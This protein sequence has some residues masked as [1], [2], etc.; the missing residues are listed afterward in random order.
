MHR[1]SPLLACLLLGAACQPVG[2]ASIRGARFDYNQAIAGSWD[3]QLLLNLVRLRYRDTPQF[4][5]IGSVLARYSLAGGASAGATIG[6]DGTRRTATAVGANIAYEETPTITYVPLQGEEFTRHLLTPIGAQPLFLLAQS[7]WSIERLLRCCVQQ[8]NGIRN[9]PSTAGPTPVRGD[10]AAEF[11]ALAKLLRELQI[12][13]VLAG[14]VDGPVVPPGVAAGGD[15][16]FVLQRSAEAAADARLADLRAMLSLSDGCAEFP[17][18]AG[19]GSGQGCSIVMQ[20]RSL[21]G[22]MFFLSLGVEAPAADAQAGLVTRSVDQRGVAFDWGLLV[23]ELLRVRCAASEPERAFVRVRYRDHWWY[24]DDA[25]LESKSTF[26]LLTWL[27][28]L[29]S[30]SPAGVGPILTVGA[31]G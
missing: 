6:V 31:G 4:L 22:V 27:F 14:L 5:Q 13:G 24:I 12:D 2:P 20:T 29:Q 26:C 3:E 11:V 25:D 7:G 15:T 10:D 16:R 8:I 17:V 21:L 30:T 23:G 9:A 19:L 28:N 1:R 18:R